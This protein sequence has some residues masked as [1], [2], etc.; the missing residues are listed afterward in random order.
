[1]I[2]LNIKRFVILE[3]QVNGKTVVVD[4]V[5][6]PGVNRE[7]KLRILDKKGKNL[8]CKFLTLFQFERL[9]K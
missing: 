4:H 3:D 2:D 1:M 8:Y 7:F 5:K 9:L 6:Q